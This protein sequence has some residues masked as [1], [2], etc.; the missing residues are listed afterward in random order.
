[1]TR[2]A[3][4]VR[5]FGHLISGQAGLS[6]AA[7]IVFSLQGL[8]I[9]LTHAAILFPPGN[10]AAATLAALS[11]GIP[12]A[13][14]LAARWQGSR[15]GWERVGAIAIVSIYVFALMFRSAIIYAMDIV[16]IDVHP[17]LATFALQQVFALTTF[18]VI[19][20][21]TAA[22]VGLA[23]ERALLTAQLQGEQARLR[24]MADS[25]EEELHEAEREL[26]QRAREILEPEMAEIRQLLQDRVGADEA[27]TVADRLM[28]AVRD[29]VRPVSQNLATPHTLPL[30]DI[31]VVVP[32]RLDPTRD[33]M[34]VP[35]AIRPEWIFSITF[36]A[37]AVSIVMF[38]MSWIQVIPIFITGCACWILL[39]VVKRAWP[40]RWREMRVITGASVV[41]ALFV[42]I[43][44]VRRLVESVIFGAS[45]RVP[46]P[47]TSFIIAGG[48]TVVVT[49]LATLSEHAQRARRDLVTVN[50]QL[51]ELVASMRRQ[52]WLSHRAVS[53][54]VHGP[55]QSV[56]VSTAMRLRTT[57]A[58]TSP[59]VIE[60]RL[61]Q[62]LEAI[63]APGIRSVTILDTLVELQALWEGIVDINYDIEP[64]AFAAMYDDPGLATC[65]SEVCREA[66]NNSIRHGHARVVNLTVCDFDSGLE[67]TVTDDGCGVP[68]SYRHGLGLAMM[69]QT[70]WQWNLLNR[71][72]GGAILHAVLV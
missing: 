16:V 66:V 2:L 69:D 10:G 32:V 6:P 35:N 53:L 52:V 60:R 21:G 63:S 64:A 20:L 25:M 42:G 24:E 4:A 31:P 19:T 62:A 71:A 56:L 61:E 38:Q 48:I 13:F 33:R 5:R 59:Q 14:L 18:L 58:E 45:E 40:A 49:A 65:A 67:I 51:E 44:I 9:S 41:V 47:L 30:R 27:D 8:L 11:V 54:T 12:A 36:L 50:A 3:D 22:A 72:Q 39:L 17:P 29:V 15:I 55:L 28:D 37:L 7:I 68:A 23:R 34:N 1:M 26:R 46:Q 70:C 43:F 57:P